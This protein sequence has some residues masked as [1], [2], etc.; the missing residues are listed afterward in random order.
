L[1]RRH[2]KKRSYKYGK[3]EKSR[4]V[5]AAAV[6]LFIFFTIIVH[7]NDNRSVLSK[8]KTSNIKIGE[9]SASSVTLRLY[10]LYTQTVDEI[11]IE[12]YVKGVVIGEMPLDFDIEALKAQAVCARTYAYYYIKGYGTSTFA[13]EHDAVLASSHLYGQEWLPEDK[14]SEKLGTGEKAQEYL[15]KLSEAVESTKGEIITYNGEPIAAFFFSSSGGQ[16]ENASSVFNIDAPYLVSVSSPEDS[17]G[18]CEKTYSY[19]EF[20]NAVNSAYN[21]NLTVSNIAE[22]VKVIR[23]T[24]SGRADIIQL[25]NKTVTGV[26]L[27]TTLGLRSTNMNITVSSGVVKIATKG[28][29][30]GVGMSQYGANYMAK[31][32]STY[33]EIIKHYYTG[34]DIE[35]IIDINK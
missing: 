2:I 6:I 18:A 7:F 14:Y 31:S 32:G 1:R 17:D 16:T 33:T 15:D 35:Q 8:I 3:K 21:T 27:R 10:N 5:T 23:R 4:I 11:D 25:G 9:S 24:A 26:Q 13:K 28:Y 20:I 22:N 29:G 19:S 34:V 30:H 12:E